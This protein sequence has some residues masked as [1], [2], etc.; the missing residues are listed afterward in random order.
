MSGRKKL[1]LGGSLLGGGSLV[2]PLGTAGLGVPLLAR[3][4]IVP[5]AGSGGGTSE[6][7]GSLPVGGTGEGLGGNGLLLN[8]GNLLL[9]GLLLSLSLGVAVCLLAFTH[10]TYNW[11]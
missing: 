10:F 4:G 3:G 7:G 9:L 11:V 6:A 1:P 2:T 8:S 5:A